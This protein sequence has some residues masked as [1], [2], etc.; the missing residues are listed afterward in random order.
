MTQSLVWYIILVIVNLYNKNFTSQC[1]SFD[2]TGGPSV[3]VL[4]VSQT[5][6]PGATP[7]EKGVS[8]ML[9]LWMS[10]FVKNILCSALITSNFPSVPKLK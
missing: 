4:Q 6:V 10:R 3:P 1:V 7:K 8:S 2:L 5:S 9:I